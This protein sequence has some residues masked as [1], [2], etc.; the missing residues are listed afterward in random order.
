MIRDVPHDLLAK[1]PEWT[2]KRDGYRGWVFPGIE[3]SQQLKEFRKRGG[4]H[5]NNVFLLYI[6]LNI[7]RRGQ[8]DR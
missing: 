1:Y 6:I 8:S 2:E 7:F 5:R 3:A 4:A